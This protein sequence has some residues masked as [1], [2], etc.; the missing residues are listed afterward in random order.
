MLLYIQ[1]C[2]LKRQSNCIRMRP[3]K[4]LERTERFYTS[5]C[6]RSRLEKKTE[7]IKYFGRVFFFPYSKQIQDI[8]DGLTTV[9]L[10]RKLL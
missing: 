5:T 1:T 7:I 8:H 4:R 10:F 9:I 3:L 6:P 2:P